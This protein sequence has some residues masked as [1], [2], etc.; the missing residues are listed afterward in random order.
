M[1]NDKKIFL[2][3]YCLAIKE[4]M[5]IQIIYNDHK[6]NIVFLNND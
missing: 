5:L 6:M 3:Q 2:K 1:L 4:Y